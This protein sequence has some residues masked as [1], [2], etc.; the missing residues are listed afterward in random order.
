MQIKSISPK[1]LKL[2]T[3]WKSAETCKRD[4]I[5]CDGAVRSGKTLFMGISFIIWAMFSFDGA[6]FAICGKSIASLRRNILTQVLPTLSHSGFV[7]KEKLSENKL[8]VLCRDRENTFFLFGGYDEKSASLIQ[9]ITLA[10]VLMDEAALMPRS[11]VEQAC[12][13]CS[14]SGSKIWFNCNPEGP[15]H[16]FYRQWIA[17]AEKKNALYLHFTMDDNP[18]LTQSVRARYENMYSGVFYRRFILGQWVA[19][20]GVIYDFF[21]ESYIADVPQ[22]E[23]EDYVISCDYGTVNPTSMGLWGRYG[24][25]WYRVEEYYFDSRAQ[26]C[27]KTDE[28]YADALE[29]LAGGKRVSRVVVDPSA[30]SFIEALRRRGHNVIKAE[31]DVLTG[32]RITSDLLKR[33]KIVI[34]RGCEDIIREFSLYVWDEKVSD[35]PVKKNDHAM[36]DMRYFAVTVASPRRDAFA[37]VAVPR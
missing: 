17:Q 15:G 24:G 6:Q 31:N 12:A 34:C 28:E 29:S 8:T 9:G 5:I 36:D 30:A 18:S 4:V 23:A 16:W 20:R 35:T 13:R 21:D 2:L 19:S 25:V 1:Q 26:G 22:E 14:V 37:A 27:Q 7:I 33:R 3:W 10:G 32:I 11:F